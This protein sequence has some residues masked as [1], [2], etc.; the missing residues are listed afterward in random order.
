VLICW[1]VLQHDVQMEVGVNRLPAYSVTQ[2]A[3]MVFCTSQSEG[4]GVGHLILTLR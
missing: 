4:R 2:G 3:I 1:I